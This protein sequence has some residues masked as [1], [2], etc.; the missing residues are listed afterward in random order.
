MPFPGTVAPPVPLYHAGDVNR[1]SGPSWLPYDSLPWRGLINESGI[2]RVRL[3]VDLLRM[4]RVDGQAGE[5]VWEGR[6]GV[7]VGPRGLVLGKVGG[8]G[9]GGGFLGKAL[10]GE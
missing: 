3:E 8:E 9:L 5:E 6:R 4:F 10:Q 7:V 2:C 1:L